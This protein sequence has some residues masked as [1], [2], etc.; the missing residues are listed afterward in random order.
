MERRH[1]E[2]HNP[3]RGTRAR[4]AKKAA[5]KL[6]VPSDAEIRI[7]EAS[8]KPELRAAIVMMAQA[9]LRVGALPSLSIT[10][11][12]WTATTKGKDQ[13]GKVP[14]EARKAITTA[15]LSL[16]SPFKDWTAGS[17][18]KAFE[19]LARK[20]REAGRIRARYSVHDLRHAF[21][22]RLYQE[23]HDVYQVE[24][25][26]GHANVGVTEGYLRSIGLEM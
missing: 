13:A 14:E 16:R 22:V 25:A 10:G 7:L 18:A 26:L 24:K 11:P 20:L 1:P 3:F 9:G 23:T 8:A 2:L 21:A 17:I 12:R 19:Y 6:A 4:P 15:G 5:R